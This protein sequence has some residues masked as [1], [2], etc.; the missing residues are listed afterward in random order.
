MLINIVLC[1]YSKTKM[2]HYIVLCTFLDQMFSVFAQRTQMTMQQKSGW[3]MAK[4]I[5]ANLCKCILIF[6]LNYILIKKQDKLNKKANGWVS[7]SDK[8]CVHCYY[9]QW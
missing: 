6:F 5:S 1:K 7:R 4:C 2:C 9:K 8:M 3:T